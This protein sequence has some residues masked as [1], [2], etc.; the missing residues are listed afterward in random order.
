MFN[1]SGFWVLRLD[2]VMIKNRTE[3]AVKIVMAEIQHCLLMGGVF[4]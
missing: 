2:N 3:E 1:R 4:H